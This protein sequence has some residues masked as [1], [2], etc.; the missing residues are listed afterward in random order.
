VGIKKDYMQAIGMLLYLVH[1]AATAGCTVP[2][3]HNV[4]TV[5]QM[6]PKEDNKHATALQKHTKVTT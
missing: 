1:S 2:E 3:R 5:F 4:S 6:F